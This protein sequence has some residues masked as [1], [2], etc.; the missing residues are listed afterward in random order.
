LGY[1]NNT[2][3]KPTQKYFITIYTMLTRECVVFLYLCI[4]TCSL[5]AMTI[6]DVSSNSNEPGW[7]LAMTIPDVSSNSNEPGWLLAMTIPD[8]SSN[9]NEPLHQV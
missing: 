2:Y 5:V 8:V 4:K 7:L 3:S 6:S 9:S 1:K